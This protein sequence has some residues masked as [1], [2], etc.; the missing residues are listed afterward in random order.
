MRSAMGGRMSRTLAGLLPELNIEIVPNSRNWCR[1]ARQTCGGRTLARIFRARGHS[2]LRC[3]LM[4]FVETPNK[5][6][7]IAPVIR[8]ISDILRAYPDLFGDRWFQVIDGIDLV[9]LFEVASANRRIA[10]PRSAIGTLVF[11]RM[12]QHFPDRARRGSKPA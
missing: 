12:R 4:T 3:V 6:A 7:L 8:A 10:Q 1:A 11:E 5:K 9:G 2:H